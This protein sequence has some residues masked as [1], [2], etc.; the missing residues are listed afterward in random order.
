MG[1]CTI[2]RHGG[3]LATSSYPFP[4][5]D[6]KSSLPGAINMGLADGHAQL[7]NLRDLWTYYWNYTWRPP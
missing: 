1:C 6:P 3:K 7:V 5:T 4:L 2:L